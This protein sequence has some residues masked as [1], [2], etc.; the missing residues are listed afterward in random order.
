MAIRENEAFRSVLEAVPRYYFNVCCDRFEATDVI[1]EHCR[2][3]TAAHAW[4]LR[5]ARAIVRQQL[6]TED[7]PQ[8]GWIEVEDEQHRAVLR[9]PLKSAAY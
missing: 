5:T 1:G 6:E 4:A 3:R 8:R 7:L 2:D 9:V